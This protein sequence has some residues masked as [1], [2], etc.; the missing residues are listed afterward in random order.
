MTGTS[1]S[2]SPS[3]WTTTRPSWGNFRHRCV[4]SVA[5]RY[6]G[7]VPSLLGGA[8]IATQKTTSAVFSTVYGERAAVHSSTIMTYALILLR[9][10]MAYYRHCGAWVNKRKGRP[11]QPSVESA[12]V[13]VVHIKLIFP[14]IYVQHIQC[15]SVCPYRCCPPG[16][17]SCVKLC[18]C[19]GYKLRERHTCSTTARWFGYAVHSIVVMYGWGAFSPS[20][21]KYVCTNRRP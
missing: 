1:R 12:A 10:V 16:E 9:G 4:H 11:C 3:V 6:S 14:P 17:T 15:T 2:S 8:G 18:Y 21:R 20:G 7:V 19:C 5:A 13:C